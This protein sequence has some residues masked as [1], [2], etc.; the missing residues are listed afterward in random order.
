MSKTPLPPFLQPWQSPQQVP[1]HAP[2]PVHT[3]YTHR[4][5]FGQAQV[6]CVAIFAHAHLGLSSYV[7]ANCNDDGSRRSYPDIASVALPAQ[8]E[9]H[10][11]FLDEL[12][13]A[14]DDPS[15]T[16]VL[17]VGHS[18]GC[19]LIQEVIKAR[20]TALSSR[21]VGVFMLFPVISHIAR[22]PNG[23][24]LSLLCRP[25]W[26]RLVA[27][28]SLLMGYAPLYI[29][30]LAQPS[31]PRNQLQVLHGLLKAPAAIYSIMTMANSEMETLRELDADFLRGLAEGLWI[32]Y[33][34]DDNWVGEQREIVL[35]ALRGTYAEIQGRIVLDRDNGIPH[36][37]CINH[38]AEIASQCVGWMRAGGF[39]GDVG[40]N[41]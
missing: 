26:P 12:L 29:L 6:L 5:P 2:V 9:A 39:L 32:H 24:K 36:S 21:D 20:R 15:A 31:W 37:F 25:P 30:G 11:R 38:S 35:S 23:K 3:V 1:P 27:Y 41:C 28:L 7:G 8:I 17:L 10:T 40:D 34:E 18:I 14:Y 4:R 19:W 13:T 16:R 22:T 33:A